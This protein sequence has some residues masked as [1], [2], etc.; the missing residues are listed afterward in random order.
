MV[1][2]GRKGKREGK[3]RYKETLLFF[4]SYNRSGN[5]VNKL[6]KSVPI[7][8]ANQNGKPNYAPSTNY[9]RTSPEKHY[10]FRIIE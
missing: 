9:E 2:G 6:S 1:L 3:E 8:K 5:Y 10:I 7:S 4:G